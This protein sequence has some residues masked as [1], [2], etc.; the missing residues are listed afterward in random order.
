MLSNR[1]GAYPTDMHKFDLFVGTLG[2][3]VVTTTYIWVVEMDAVD[4]VGGSITTYRIPTLIPSVPVRSVGGQHD[5]RSRCN[6][7]FGR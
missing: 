7:F 3:S 4:G 1:V 2:T 6:R 5:S